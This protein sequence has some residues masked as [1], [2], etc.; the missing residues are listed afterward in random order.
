MVSRSDGGERQV[1][2]KKNRLIKNASFSYVYKRGVA[3]HARGLSLVA[4][5]SSGNAVKIGF[6]VGSK[7][8]KAHDRN[9]VKRR[10]RAIAAAYL[11]KINGGVQVVFTTKSE[12]REYD[13]AGLKR[14]VEALLIR[15]K[16][17]SGI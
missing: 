7:V 2:S 11:P 1:L 5:R 14:A 13:F 8:G 16:L 15:A 17:I 6:S 12:V 10:L 3:A 4:V 9:L